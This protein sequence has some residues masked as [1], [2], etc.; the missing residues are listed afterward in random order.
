MSSTKDYI[1]SQYQQAMS[2]LRLSRNDDERCKSLGE[3]S[4]L[5][6]LASEMYGF[7]FADSLRQ[8]Q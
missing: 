2:D 1:K 5:T 4:R 3:L 6:N 7:D 8:L